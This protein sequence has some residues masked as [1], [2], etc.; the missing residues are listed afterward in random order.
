MGRQFYAV[1]VTFLQPASLLFMVY[2]PM[3]SLAHA[4]RLQTVGRLK[5]EKRMERCSLALILGTDTAWRVRDKPRKSAAV[6][7]SALNAET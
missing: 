5:N 3:L 2:L 7:L 4:V 1:P 6:F